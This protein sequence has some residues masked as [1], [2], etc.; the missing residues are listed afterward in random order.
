[1]KRVITSH[2]MTV[3]KGKNNSEKRAPSVFMAQK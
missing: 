1:V 2:K 3:N